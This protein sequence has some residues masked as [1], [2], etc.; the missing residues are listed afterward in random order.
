MSERPLNQ[1]FIR[2]SGISA[3]RILSTKDEGPVDELL[4]S[5]T[6]SGTPAMGRYLSILRLRHGYLQMAVEVEIDHGGR[7]Q[8]QDLAQREFA[9]GD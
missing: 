7:V 8:H 9:Q 1:R 6:G 4:D 2:L 3:H 5:R